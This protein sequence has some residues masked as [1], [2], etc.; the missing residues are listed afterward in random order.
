MSIIT[1]KI[2]IKIDMNSTSSIQST[3]KNKIENKFFCPESITNIYFS[4]YGKYETR[5]CNKFYLFDQT[6]SKHKLARNKVISFPT[7]YKKK[8]LF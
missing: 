3:N 1:A 2:E 6:N 5:C 7:A 4:S 8:N